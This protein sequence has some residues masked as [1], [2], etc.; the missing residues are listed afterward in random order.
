MMFSKF[1]VGRFFLVNF[2]YNFDHKNMNWVQQMF[3]NTN[4]YNYYINNLQ[5]IPYDTGPIE[6]HASMTLV[7]LGCI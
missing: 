5:Y 6:L 1:G 4:H 3:Q 2:L 7:I